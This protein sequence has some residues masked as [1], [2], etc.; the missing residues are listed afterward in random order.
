MRLPELSARPRLQR[1]AGW[2]GRGPAGRALPGGPTHP[3]FLAGGAGR[4]LP[5]LLLSTLATGGRS[6]LVV[7]T[8]LPNMGVDGG[9][10]G[11]FSPGTAD[12][13]GRG[14]NE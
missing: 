10:E 9:C 4:A 5:G 13:A 2:A 11:G 7:G 6:L 12:G 14:M 8:Q 1:E 3:S